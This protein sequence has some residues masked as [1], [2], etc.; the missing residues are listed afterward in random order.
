MGLY[1]EHILPVLVDRACG[2]AG[3]KKWRAELSRGLTG[4]VLEVG[5]GS[6]LNVDHYPSTVERVLA[7]EPSAKAFR[8]A[9]RRIERSPVPIELVGLDGQLIPL[10][11]DSCDHALCTFALCTIP[12]VNAALA[13]VGRVLR[14]GGRLHFLEHGLSP[15]PGVAAW[16][17]RLEPLQ[18]RVADGCHL[19]RD[20]VALVRD[21]G[22]G[23]GLEDI[24][25]R[26][27]IGPKPWS[28]FTRGVAVHPG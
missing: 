19:T 28:W 12:D 9:Q 8:I 14:P 22:F 24:D 13:E 11:D 6:G 2:T 1:R 27:G 21:A 3:L 7:V 23:L 20:P 15:D 10:P 25:Q 26:Y 18:R 17:R 4:R 5:F 16:Q